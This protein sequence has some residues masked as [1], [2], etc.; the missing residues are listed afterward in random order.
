MNITA[1]R[2]IE[3]CLDGTKNIEKTMDRA[4]DRKFI[5]H[6]GALGDLEYFSEFSRPFFRITRPGAFIIKGV[7][8][9]NSFEVFIIST[10]SD[11]DQEI[12][13]LVRRFNPANR[14]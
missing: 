13:T 9:A 14:S 11:P 4:I 12:E 10:S 7:E 5:C 1:T 8:G 6:L 3:T 2:V